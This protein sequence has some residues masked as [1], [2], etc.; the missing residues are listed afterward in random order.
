[1]G[2]ITVPAC[3]EDTA[4]HAL[5]PPPVEDVELDEV[6]ELVELVPPAMVVPFPVVVPPL[7]VVVV[8]VL[9][10]AVLF[11]FP[12]TCLFWAGNTYAPWSFTPTTTS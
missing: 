11:P 12:V 2:L 4:V 1:M 6:V 5:A 9:P 8:V 10:V 3:A 7:P